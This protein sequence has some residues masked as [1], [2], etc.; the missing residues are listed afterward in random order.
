MFRSLCTP[1]AFA[2]PAALAVAAVVAV[3]ALFEKLETVGGLGVLKVP[4]GAEQATVM[5]LRRR[6]QTASM[7]PSK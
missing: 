5:P 3:G 2:V 6:N 1:V 4:E 7:R